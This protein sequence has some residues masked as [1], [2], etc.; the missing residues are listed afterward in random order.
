M[1]H[2][3]DRKVW[4]ELEVDY[5]AVAQRVWLSARP[6][7]GIWAATDTGMILQLVTE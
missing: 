4:T 6:G 2:S 7:A 3:A 1:F 5:R